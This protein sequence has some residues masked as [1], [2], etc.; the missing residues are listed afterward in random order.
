MGR[1]R[2]KE[3][4]KVKISDKESLLVVVVLFYIGSGCG[5]VKRM[6]A[7]ITGSPSEYC[8]NGVVYLQFPSGATLA[9][10]QNSKPMTCK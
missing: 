4:D 9:L 3:N 6:A 8:Y 1:A 2:K 5:Q 7:G 10:D